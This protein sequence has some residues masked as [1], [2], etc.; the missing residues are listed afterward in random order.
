MQSENATKRVIKILVSVV[1]LLVDWAFAL[2]SLAVGRRTAARCVVFCYHSVSEHERVGFQ[3]QMDALLRYAKPLRAETTTPLG[4]AERYA[5][6]TFDDG[7]ESVVVNALP[8]LR[9]R[10]IPATL[11]VVT[12]GLGGF[13]SWQSFEADLHRE[14]RIMSA[15]QLQ[16]L[17]RELVSIGSHT[18]THPVL[19]AV[20]HAAARRE[21]AES[22]RKLE[23]LTGREIRL[24]SFPYGSFNQD[25]VAWCREA[26]YERVFTVE[27]ALGFVQG[28]EFVTGRVTVEPTDWAIEFHLKLRGAYR[29]I[30]CAARFKRKLISCPM[31]S[32]LSEVLTLRR[33]RGTG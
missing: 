11:F 30:S 32:L 2:L 26:E 6:V 23:Q 10:N 22:K 31:L 17:P 29:W 33:K 16:A 13:P 4:S 14:A 15:D 5:V 20:P 21:I 28:T 9:A 25:A 19:T 18:L 27:P 24:F 12:D 7:F 1:V 3:Q 8:V